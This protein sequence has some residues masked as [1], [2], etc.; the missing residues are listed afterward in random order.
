MEK[1]L[2]KKG[3]ER[4]PRL[5]YDAAQ[6]LKK[7]LG[8]VPWARHLHNS[9]FFFGSQKADVETAAQMHSLPLKAASRRCSQ[10]FF[11]SCLSLLLRFLGICL[12][13]RLEYL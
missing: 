6:Q 10:R 2:Q 8:L 13:V 11:S 7:P 9:F 3:E 1:E 4:E 12:L 5:L